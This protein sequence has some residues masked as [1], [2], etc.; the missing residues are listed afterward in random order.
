MVVYVGTGVYLVAALALGLL[1]STVV[2][3]QQQAQF[4]TFFVLVLFFFLGGLFTPV[5]SMPEWVQVI[6]EGNPIKHFVALLRGVL[7]K[8]AM[9][10]DVVGPILA[11]ALF[12]AVTLALA[13]WR[14]RKTAA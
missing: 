5:A 4:L 9:F 3:T 10:S 11:M 12:G 6:A 1:I 13:V 14:Y 7:M 2:S 8:G